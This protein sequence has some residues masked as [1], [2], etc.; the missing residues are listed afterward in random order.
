MS[1]R[2]PRH[3]AVRVLKHYFRLVCEKAG[4]PFDGD[5]ASE[6]AG[7]VDDIIEAAANVRTEELRITGQLLD[8]RNRVLAALPCPLHGACVPH[9]LEV[10]ER[11]KAAAHLV[12]DKLPALAGAHH[13]ALVVRIGGRDEFYEADWL[14]ELGALLSARKAS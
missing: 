6:V 2:D 3:E 10:I 13:T 5:C 4:V 14:K 7:I 8:D 11:L 1:G 12:Q 9:A